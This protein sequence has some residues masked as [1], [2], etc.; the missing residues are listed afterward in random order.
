[1]SPLLVVFALLFPGLNAT[2]AHAASF[3]CAKATTPDERTVCSDSQLS[4]L[5]NLISNAFRQAKQA[6]TGAD[7]QKNIVTFARGFL[8]DRRACAT[9]R[10]CILGQYV[11][12]LL[13]YQNF[14]AKE[15]V[16]AW[17]TAPAI[18]G[19]KGPSGTALPTKIG[20]CASTQIIDVTPRLDVGHPPT[21]EDFDAGTAVNYRNNGH[22]VSYEREPA[23]LHSRPGDKVL[24][25]LVSIPQGCPPGDNRGRL[26]TVTNS[27][28]GETWTLPDSQH[29]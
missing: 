1:M 8:K 27:R 21:N 12:A 28:T 6:S 18:M 3:D 19:D 2:S 17:V 5:D 29:S 15:A 9:D 23:L 26:Y 14:G 11:S 24:M 16:P 25:C 22:Q 13:A 4:E 10:S 7:D 20:L